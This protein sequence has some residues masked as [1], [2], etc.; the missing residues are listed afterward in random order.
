MVGAHIHYCTLTP[1]PPS[2]QECFQLAVARETAANTVSLEDL[3]SG[4]AR[5]FAHVHAAVFVSTFSCPTCTVSADILPE[6]LGFD[7]RRIANAATDFQRIID[8]ATTLVVATHALLHR[9]NSTNVTQQPSHDALHTLTTSLLETEGDLDVDTI[10]ADFVR[11]LDAANLIPDPAERAN[12]RKAFDAAV[13][14][15]DHVRTL[16]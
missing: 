9:D 7:V 1:I 13:N 8:G 16:M 6:T 2:P 10:F 5:A 11:Q 14:K 3:A 4:Q 12:L 15:Q